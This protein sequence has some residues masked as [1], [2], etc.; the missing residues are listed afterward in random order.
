MARL[1]G[2]AHCQL[3]STSADELKE[4]L[5]AVAAYAAGGLVALEDANRRQTRKV[6]LLGKG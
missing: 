1:T 5:R 6:R 2:G 3:S 4:L